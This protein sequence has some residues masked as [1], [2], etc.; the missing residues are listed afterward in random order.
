MTEPLNVISFYVRAVL[1]LCL[2]FIAIKYYQHYKKMIKTVKTTYML[3]ACKITL[4]S[5]LLI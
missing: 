1:C 5:T 4:S 2:Y 3:V